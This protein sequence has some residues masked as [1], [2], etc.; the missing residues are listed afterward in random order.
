MTR[1]VA[2]ERVVKNVDV[3]RTTLT[4]TCWCFRESQGPPRTKLTAHTEKIICSY[5]LSQDDAKDSVKIGEGQDF[6]HHLGEQTVAH[7]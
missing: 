4:Q 7:V 5:V 3:K 2:F 6:F 1:Q